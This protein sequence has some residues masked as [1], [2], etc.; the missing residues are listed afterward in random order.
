MAEWIGAYGV[1]AVFAGGIL[2]GEAVFIA[3]GYA[4]SQGYLPAGPA[5]LAAVLGATAGDHGWYLA[6]RF[7]GTPLLRR[8]PAFRRVHGR[9]VL[10]ARRWGRGAAFG[11]RFAYGLR[12]VLPLSLGAARFPPTLFVPLN[13]LGSVAFALVYLTLGY[14]FGEAA[15]RLFV[16]VRG[17]AP[18]VVVA[19]V[20]VGLVCWAIREWSLFRG[21][22]GAG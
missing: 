19:V 18:Q 20:L 7:W 6:G 11:L 5:L 13:A 4:V 12:S 17:F 2:E 3:A 16:R 1:W 22:R 10:W 15:E 9:A 8:V 14:F 21:R